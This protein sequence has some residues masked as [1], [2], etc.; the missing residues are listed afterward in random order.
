M[1]LIKFY[2]FMKTEPCPCGSGKKYRACCMNKKDQEL[3]FEKVPYK[4]REGAF[5]NYAYKLDKES[6]IKE[7]LYP[8]SEQCEG[9]I[10]SAHSLQNNGV[11]SKISE[12]G[13]VVIP[14]TDYGKDDLIYDVKDVSK[15]KATTFTG[16]CDK[17]DTL[18]FK[19]IETKEIDVTSN[20]QC[21]LFAYRAFA[22]ELH[23]KKEALKS[24]QQL[25]EVR[26]T[27]SKEIEFIAQYRYAELALN[28]LSVY[29]KFFDKA[30][31]N[32]NYDLIQ[33]TTFTF[34]YEVSMAAC[35]G[36][37]LTY[38]IKGNKMNDIHSMEDERLK[39][40]FF[41]IIPN[42]GKTYFIFSWIKYDNVF[43]KDYIQQLEDL[44]EEQFKT[45][46]NNFLPSYTENL[47]I[48]PSLWS[49]FTKHQKDA[50]FK[51]FSADVETN[52]N[53]LKANLLRSTSYDLLVNHVRE[54]KVA[55]S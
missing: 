3:P 54:E 13:H 26:P 35:G 28:D 14:N 21:F 40:L 24:R 42:N 31:I 49:S 33:S 32:E 5:K 52:D 18:V 48:A 45:Y 22:L 20:K 25:F 51:L 36:F 1:E 10:K 19:D 55:E 12:N 41:T 43:F 46:I 34:D 4:N 7:C 27:L 6:K 8:N 50:F 53:R 38:D 44:T 15:N 47:V 37:T 9:K 39:T 16:F 29:K 2:K 11:L 23:K 30:L 17:H